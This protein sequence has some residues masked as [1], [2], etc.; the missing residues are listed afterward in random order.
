VPPRRRGLFSRIF[1]R[2]APA[3]PAAPAP[4]VPQPRGFLSR[5]FRR[6][7]PVS[8]DE[9]REIW[10]RERAEGEYRKQLAVFRSA[11][12][13]LESDPDELLDLWRSYVQ[14]IV[15]GEGRY[16]RNSSSNMFWRDL[17]LDPRD[18]DWAGWRVAMGYK[19]RQR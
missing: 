14:H 17:G 1:R 10:D 11:A 18:F 16:R 7:A 12:E 2:Q 15:N 6:P 19:A 13:P 5:I 8:R 4:P 9:Y 3:R